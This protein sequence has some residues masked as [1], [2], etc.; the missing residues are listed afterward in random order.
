MIAYA[1]TRAHGS[2]RPALLQAAIRAIHTTVPNSA[3]HRRAWTLFRQLRDHD[4]VDLGCNGLF[5]ELAKVT[6]S[7]RHY[8]RA[9]M[10]YAIVA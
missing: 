10:L 7:K 1:L 9:M 5:W 4:T 3:D 8:M 6:L 2:Y